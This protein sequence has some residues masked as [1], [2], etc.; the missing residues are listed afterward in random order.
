MSKRIDYDRLKTEVFQ[1]P[2]YTDKYLSFYSHHPIC[3]KSVTRSLF[4][5]AQGIPSSFDSSESKQKYLFD[6]LK[7]NKYPTNFL[8]NCL[9]SVRPPRTNTENE[10]SMMDFA[11]VPNIQRITEPIKRILGSFNVKVVKKPFMTLSHIFAKTMV[12]IANEQRKDVIYSTPYS[13]CD[14]EYISQTKRQFGT[15]LREYQK[16]VFF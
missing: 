16:A 14:Q 10:N 15:C 12:R 5:R 4:L 9:K 1:K 13:N 3:H 2:T 6:V 8:K 7:A 11:I